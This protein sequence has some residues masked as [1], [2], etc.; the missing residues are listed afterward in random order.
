MNV[1]L[2]NKY[3]NK[4]GNA[5]SIDFVN[6]IINYNNIKNVYDCKILIMY[7]I[8]EWFKF[9]RKILIVKHAH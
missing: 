4:N 3:I 8:I 1:N 5:L 6:K 9:E 7:Y 2:L